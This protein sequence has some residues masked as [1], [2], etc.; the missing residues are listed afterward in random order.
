MHEPAPG[1]FCRVVADFFTLSEPKARK[2]VHFQW[3]DACWYLVMSNEDAPIQLPR[4]GIRAALQEARR[5][6]SLHDIAARYDIRSMTPREMVHLAEELYMA[7]FLSH[8]QYADLSFQAELMPNYD[9]TIGALTGQRAAPDKPRDYA[10]IW[11]A[12]LKF[13]MKHLADDPRIV[14]RTRKILELLRAIEKPENLPQTIAAE[15]APRARQRT[16]ARA[17]PSAVDLPPLSLR[18]APDECW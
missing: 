17:T 13:E 15:P 14:A 7:G 11:R 1:I 6:P 10:S 12:K 5:S 8:E 16:V 18:A 4:S 9:T 3:H 2:S